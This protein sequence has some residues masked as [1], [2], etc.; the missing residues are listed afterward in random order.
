V[1]AEPRALRRKVA[2]RPEP[3]TVEIELT[4]GA[5]AG[6]WARILV[7]FPMRV[8]LEIESGKA[9]RVMAALDGIIVDHNFP[10]ADGER[11]ASIADVDPYTGMVAIADRFMDAMRSVPNR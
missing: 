9:E 2:K 5:F 1:S 10:G 7:D 3:R 4:E 8:M 11:A 6:W